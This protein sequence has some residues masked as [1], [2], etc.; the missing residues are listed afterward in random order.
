M[1]LNSKNKNNI[2][3][4]SFLT[5]GALAILYISN[6]I[7]NV[8]PLYIIS[9]VQLIISVISYINIQKEDKKVFKYLLIKGMMSIFDLLCVLVDVQ[10]RELN[11]WYIA[12]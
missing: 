7:N 3:S 9:I 8:I 6:L 2:D 12:I 10:I 11:R 5:I 1:L 4:I